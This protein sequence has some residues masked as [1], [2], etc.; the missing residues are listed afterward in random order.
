MTQGKEP[1][2][3]L[4]LFKNKPLIVYKNGTSRQGGQAPAAP[5]R[6]F[7]VRRNLGTITRICEVSLY[8]IQWRVIVTLI[9]ICGVSFL[10]V[11]RQVEAVALSLNSNDAYLLK[12]PEGNGYVWKGKGASEEEEQGAKYISEKLKCK[13]KLINEGQEPG[14]THLTHE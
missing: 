3:L 14:K 10:F 11:V 12:L 9:Y 5:I 7:Q 8:I 13:T 4:S 2:H 1:P 6:L